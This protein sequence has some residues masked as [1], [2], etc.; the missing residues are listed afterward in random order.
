MPNSQGTRVKF[1]RATISKF[2][3]DMKMFVKQFGE[4]EL[5]KKLRSVVTRVPLRESKGILAQ[6]AQGGSGSLEDRGLLVTREK[7]SDASASILIGGGRAKKNIH[8]F[9]AHWVELGTSGIV[10]DGGVKYK[11]GTRYRS[12]TK[13]IHFLERGAENTKNQVFGSIEKSFAKAFKKL[14]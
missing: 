10:R 7:N 9:M 5:E 11:S 14:G 4:K 8:G 2:N 13:G 6:E 1:D 3:K 12:P